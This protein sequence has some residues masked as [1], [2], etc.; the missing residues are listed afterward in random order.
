MSRQS[1]GAVTVAVPW[2]VVEERN[3]AEVLTR[4]Q[5]REPSVGVDHF[6][7]AFLDITREVLTDVALGDQGETF[8]GVERLQ[9][10]GETFEIGRSQGS[11]HRQALEKADVLQPDPGSVSAR[12]TATCAL[13]ARTGRKTAATTTVEVTPRAVITTAARTDPISSEAS[14]APSAPT[15][16][17]GESGVGPVA[18]SSFPSRRPVS[19]R[20]PGWRGQSAPKPVLEGRRRGAAATRTERDLVSSMARSRVRPM[21]STSEYRSDETTDTDRRVEQGHA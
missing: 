1:V 4:P 18:A 17:P 15:E 7:A 9:L 10:D 20:Y 3:L 21:S 6:G 8:R 5:C 2:H 14:A 16:D 11:E 12:T 13:K 19:A